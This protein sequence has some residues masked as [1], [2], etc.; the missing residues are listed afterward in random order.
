[1]NL[2]TNI[3]SIVT[4]SLLISLGLV[5]K[6]EADNQLKTTTERVIIFK[7]GFSMIIKS[8][9]ATTNEKGEV[10]FDDV[11]D[12]AILGSFWATPENGRLVSMTAGWAKTDSVEERAEL[13]FTHF[14]ILIAN[15]GRDCSLTV[16]KDQKMEGTILEVLSRKVKSSLPGP[17]PRNGETRTIENFHGS[18]FILRN[19]DGDHLIKVS[20]I[21]QLTI[22]NMVSK[23][24]KKVNRTK[25]H[26][27]LTLR[28]EKPN[29]KHKIRIMYFR[30]GLRWIPTYRL[31]LLEKKNKKGQNLATLNLQAEILNEAEDLNEV[32]IDIVVGVPNFRFKNT[33]S[34]LVLEATLRRT[35]VQA[36]PQ[37]MNRGQQFSNAMY[38]QRSSEFRRAA[39]NPSPAAGSLNLPGE[40]TAK[41]SQDLFVYKL[42]AITLKKS[43]RCAVPIFS[44]TVPYKD[45][46]TWDI[47]LKNA[48][49]K[50]SASSPLAIS[51]NKVWHQIEL[52]N[53]TKLPWTTGAIMVMQGQ[54]PLS[55]ELL[56]YT[57]PG[58]AVRV[59]VTVAVEVRG[60]H[61][62]W[63][64]GREN[65][66]EKWNGYHYAKIL[67]SAKLSVCN[68]KN[69]NIKLEINLTF[70]GKVT[71]AS[72]S[73]EQRLRPHNAS[74]WPDYR[75]HTSLNNS[76]TVR[77]SVTLKPGEVF[78]P[79]VDYHYFTRQ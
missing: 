33:V 59:P 37:L 39:A 10:N 46:Y 11:P 32:P 48:S 72:N 19:A 5:S 6:A 35:L 75:N 70:G 53:A 29:L 22:K 25:K 56:T 44:A 23:L 30:P 9:E 27:R 2:K 52:T 76:S 65:K 18:S 7:D 1:V 4:L 58:D 16:G 57:S 26:K 45:V 13:C 61:R 64:T 77:W 38:N 66:S 42:P 14:E 43:Q 36:A 20:Q 73:G 8:G 3:W 34:P 55:G 31:S 12:S 50:R 41:G 51:N 69:T 40:L 79:T 63:E 15:K 24:K 47:H 54:Q 71:T 62:D 17:M 74:D 60:S 78:A 28:F 68:H 21:Q 49:A 67:K